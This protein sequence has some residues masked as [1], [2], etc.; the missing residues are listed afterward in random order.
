MN[1][2]ASVAIIIGGWMT[3]L[4]LTLSRRGNA[5]CRYAWRGVA[6]AILAVT[7]LLT[8]AGIIVVRSARRALEAFTRTRKPRKTAPATLLPKRVAPAERAERRRR[9]MPALHPEH[10]TSE[11]PDADGEWLAEAAAEL[12]PSDEYHHIL[13]AFGRQP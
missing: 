3:I 12:W 11:L 8:L 7:A 1:P 6:S 10:L 2:F 9:G 5:A 4:W 13:R